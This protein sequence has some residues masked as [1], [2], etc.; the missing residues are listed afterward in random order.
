MKKSILSG[1][2]AVLCL[3]ASC[4]SDN[5]NPFGKAKWTG[6]SEKVLYSDFLPQ[7]IISADMSFED[8]TSRASLLFGGNDPRLMDA[9]LNIMGVANGKDESFVRVELDRKNMLINVYRT[10]YTKADKPGKVFQ[11]LEIADSLL[12]ADTWNLSVTA[13]YSQLRIRLNGNNIGQ[14]NVGPLGQGGDDIAYPQLSDA[15]WM[16]EKGHKADLN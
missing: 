10:G 12:V 1:F 14:V 7:F 15:G 4:G 11:S 9:D 13:T 8:E 3:S 6:T 16:V 2:I 5:E